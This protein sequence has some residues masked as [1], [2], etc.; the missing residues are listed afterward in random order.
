MAKVTIEITDTTTN[1]NFDKEKIEEFFNQFPSEMNSVRNLIL[2]SEF[3]L[4]DI[5]FDTTDDENP[6]GIFFIRL[7]SKWSDSKNEEFHDESMPISTGG[8]PFSDEFY[9]KLYE[10][11]GG[12]Y[13]SFN[14][15]VIGGPD[16]YHSCTYELNK[17]GWS[18]YCDFYEIE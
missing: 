11:T 18:G 16:G 15:T 12:I 14:A 6:I 9:L 5:E 4:S 8:S 17:D 2:D 3:Y 13:L 1:S 10:V 7:M